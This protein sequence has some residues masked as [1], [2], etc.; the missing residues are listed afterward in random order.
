MQTLREA[1]DEYKK[2]GKAIGHFNFSDSNQLKAIAEAGKETG[3]PVIAGLSEGE[4]DFFPLVHA[5]AIIDQYQSQGI[6]IYLNADHT[7]STEKVQRAIIA[8]VDSVVVDGAKLDFDGN[9]SFASASVKYART[10]GRDVVVEGELGYIGTSS[11]QLD[12]LPEGV[13]E[14]NITTVE[15]AK[16]LVEATGIDCLAPAVGNVHGMLKSAAEPRLHPDRVKEIADATG[17]PLV[18]HGASGNTEE[19]IKACIA[20][21]VAVVHINT[22]LRVAYR[23][24]LRASLAS[25]ETTPYKFLDPAV[26]KMKEYIAQKLLL[27]A[28]K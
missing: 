22:E 19:D 11:K 24:A 4:R 25:D 10:S 3:L 5:R 23:D 14:A 12:E 6:Q 2:A 27:F 15:D 8:G 16:K 9:V 7:Y 1:I 20:T 18:L 21:G 26:V 28:G 17:L 13:T